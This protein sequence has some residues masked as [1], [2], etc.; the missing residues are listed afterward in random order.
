MRPARPQTAT[1]FAGRL[2]SLV[3]AGKHR[4]ALAYAE[5]RLFARLALFT[6][7]PACAST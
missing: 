7:G 1:Q 3:D 5:Q 6:D 4:Q 2:R